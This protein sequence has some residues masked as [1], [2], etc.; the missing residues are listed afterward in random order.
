[1]FHLMRFNLLLSVV[2]CL[3]ALCPTA[4]FATALCASAF[5]APPL[6][7]LEQAAFENASRAVQD[8][9]V[10]VETFGGA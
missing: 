10:Q 8:S 2:P 9:I 4:L 1:M 3:Y 7:E 5:C 6:E